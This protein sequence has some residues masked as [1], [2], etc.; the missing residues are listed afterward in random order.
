MAVISAPTVKYAVPCSP[1]KVSSLWRWKWVELVKPG[2]IFKILRQYLSL[3][4]SQNSFPQSLSTIRSANSA[5]CPS[6]TRS[7]DPRFQAFDFRL[8]PVSGVHNLD[9]P[10]RL[11][12]DNGFRFVVRALDQNG[13]FENRNQ[14][15]PG[16]LRQ[17]G[18]PCPPSAPRRAWPPC[19]R[20]GKTGGPRPSAGGRS[21]RS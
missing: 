19:I 20:R 7:I 8:P 18:K 1:M 6:F 11:P 2:L 12:A 3:L 15:L 17:S 16:C 10:G 9:F 21:S 5:N 4:S 14:F 13:G